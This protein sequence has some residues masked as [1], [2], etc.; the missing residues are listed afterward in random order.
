MTISIK[1]EEI[2]QETAALVENAT[3]WKTTLSAVCAVLQKNIPYYNWVGYYFANFE[4][5][6]ATF[7]QKRNRYQYLFYAF[8][9]ASKARNQIQE[10]QP[11]RL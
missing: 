8:L 1:H 7:A 5:H 6:F 2:L 11:Y 3:D 10:R 4:T 9:Q